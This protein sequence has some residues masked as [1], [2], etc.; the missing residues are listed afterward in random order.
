MHQSTSDL[1]FQA[2]SLKLSPEEER[3]FCVC[4]R[5]LITH[6]I[7]LPMGKR[8][9][10]KETEVHQG[11]QNINLDAHGWAV[12]RALRQQASPSC[13]CYL[14]AAQV[15]QPTLAT[16]GTHHDVPCIL[17]SRSTP[18]LLSETRSGRSTEKVNGT[19]QQR[20]MGR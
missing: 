12:M 10:R 2:N 1:G 11:W 13:S 14:W 4:P 6:H 16:G 9:C 5:V 20:S 3:G 18:K 7:V 19:A 15:H 17:C 8:G